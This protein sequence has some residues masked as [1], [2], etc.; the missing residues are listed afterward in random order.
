LEV[1]EYISD[2]LEGKRICGD[3]ELSAVKRWK[4]FE[5]NPD[6]YY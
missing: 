1:R 3:L 2:V 6:I 5:K 4:Q